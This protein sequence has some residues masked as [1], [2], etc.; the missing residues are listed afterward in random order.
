M[1]RLI[2]PALL[3]ASVFLLGMGTANAQSQ[4]TLRTH[5]GSAFDDMEEDALTGVSDPGSSDLELIQESTSNAASKQ[6]VGLRFTNLNIPQGA[7]IVSA[8]VQ[9]TWD[10][11][12]Q[13]D[14]CNLYIKAENAGNALP[15]LS[16]TFDLTNRTKFNDSIAWN[17]PSW[18]GG[19]NGLRDSAQLTSD[20]GSLVQ[21]I[22]N[23]PN[24]Q[25]GNAMAFFITGNG[26]RTAESFEG[27]QGHNNLN[28]APELIITYASTTSPVGAFPVP[29][30]SVWNYRSE[31]TAPA[32]N[33]NTLAFNDSTWPFGPAELGY[34]DGDEA[35][36]IPFGPS[37]SSKYPSYYFRHKFNYTPGPQAIDSLEIF[38]RRDDGVVLYLNGVE[39]FRDNMP[40]G[41]ITYNSMALTAIAGADESAWNKFVV[42][43]THLVS[44]LNVL[45]AS[46]HQDR[47]TSSDLTF[48]LYMQPKRPAIATVGVPFPKNSDWS[49]WDQGTVDST[50]ATLAFNDS[51]WDYGPGVLGYG[52]PVATLVGFGSSSSNK[53]VATWFRKKVD[54]ANYATLPDTLAFNFR[55]DDGIVVY[56]NGVEVFRDNMPAGV[57]TSTTLAVNVIDGVAESTYNTV[58]VPKTVFVSGLNVIAVSMHQQRPNS[59][60]MTFD[61]EVGMPPV[62]PAPAAG[63]TGPFDQHI[64]CFTSVEPGGQ[65]PD[66]IFPSTH[67]MQKIVEQGDAYNYVPNGV[68]FVNVPGNNDFTAFVGK[69]GSSTE[70]VIAINHENTPGGVTLVN[71]IYNSATHLWEYDTIM[72]VDFYDADLVTTSRNCSGGITPWGTILS[73][74]E[75]FSTGDANNDGYQ[76]VGWI[77]EI[78]PWTKEVMSYGNGKKEKLW[79]LGRFSHEN[80]APHP[81]SIRVY[82]TEDGGT[83]CVY[84]FVADQKTNLSSGSLYALKL[85]QP[86]QGGVPTGT[87]GTWE[88]VPNTTQADRNNTRTLAAAVGGTNFSGPEDIEVHTLDGKIYFTSKGHSRVYRFKDDGTTVSEFEVFVG[89]SAYLINYGSGFASEAWGS[90]NDNL[91]IDDRGNVWVLQDGSR[92]HIWMVTPNHTQ[93]APDVELFARTPSGSEPC[94]FEMTPDYRFGFLSIQHP[95]SS[96]SSTFQLD[97]KGDTLRFDRSTSIVIGRQEFLGSSHVG[98]MEHPNKKLQMRVFPNPA[99]TQVNLEVALPANGEVVGYI[100]D[101]QGRLVCGF[102]NKLGAGVHVLNLQLSNLKLPVGSYQILVQSNEFV[103]RETLVI[104]K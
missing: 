96:N 73:G 97:V 71:A 83:S 22:V 95:S 18:G 61:L 54:L 74:E 104:I 100:I 51:D 17:P 101:Q 24:W 28:W 50:W 68:P 76:D 53:H 60:D 66:L 34:G 81:D 91:T 85:N 39:L 41:P 77:V 70:G 36:V 6:I 9:F 80:A 86:L 25:S 79:A 59:S 29:S 103:G 37:S 35:T 49:F 15:F 3:L 46:V 7:T 69:N 65:T 40:A 57:I 88:L 58:L 12:K 4:L 19:A 38:V 93:T 8:R 90:G 21:S 48:D 94:G 78:D 44:G 55:R 26:T 72:P 14:P 98:L 42:S 10:E 87:T 5:V 89:G 20:F 1:K 63:C 31:A 11:N 47:V 32:A 30:G 13:L 82:M 52:D 43:A 84:K 102:N 45:A 62:I 23:H 16:T 75:T 2:T 64:S 56:V 99:S 67:R 27:A 33:W 92:N